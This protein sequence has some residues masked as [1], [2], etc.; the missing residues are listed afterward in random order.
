M[1]TGIA[2]ST[3]FCEKTPPE[4]LGIFKRSLSSLLASGYDG[5]IFLVDDGSTTERHLEQLDSRVRVI[6]RSHGGVARTKNTCIKVLFAEGVDIGFLADDDMFY[7]SSWYVRYAEAIQRTGIDHFSYFLESTPCEV[8]EIGGMRV[9]RTP[10]V[11]GCFLTVT[12]RLIDKIG[13]FKMLPNDYGH[14]HSNFSVR[15]ARLSGQGGFYD[16]ED[17]F[18]CLELISE[19]VGCKAIGSVDIEK[20]KENE[21]HAILMGF[22]YEPFI[23]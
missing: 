17:S 13:F 1:R 2:I 8:M 20:F 23:E 21:Q 19:S 4:R 3:Y 10:S 18:S 7:K 16:I 22:N 11:N 12:K 9:R 15:A 6:H 5:V 14:E